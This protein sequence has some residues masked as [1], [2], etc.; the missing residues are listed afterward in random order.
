V[1]LASV[2]FSASATAAMRPPAISSREDDMMI[3]TMASRL[4]LY[5]RGSCVFLQAAEI[6]KLLCG[7]AR[8][9]PGRYRRRRA[10]ITLE[11]K[12]GVRHRVPD[13]RFDPIEAGT[14]PFGRSCRGDNRRNLFSELVDT[15][16]DIKSARC[17]ATAPQAR[18]MTMS[19]NWLR[20]I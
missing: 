1:A 6:N 8:I 11:F 2:N 13:L 3:V 5:Q 14:R 17:F 15:P 4:L 10:F 12:H 19:R 20:R 18:A 7:L 16:T 9:A